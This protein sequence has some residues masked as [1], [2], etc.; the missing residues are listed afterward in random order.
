MPLNDSTW[1]AEIRRIDQ[2]FEDLRD[3]QVREGQLIKEQLAEYKSGI[4]AKLLEMNEVRRQIYEERGQYQLRE[5]SDAIYGSLF[6]R[7]SRT[8]KEQSAFT[9]RLI[10]MGAA[11][12]FFISVIELVIKVWK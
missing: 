11:L 12:L 6:D 3:S 7:I 9:G 5:K 8:E 10:G 4:T 2:R 1:Q